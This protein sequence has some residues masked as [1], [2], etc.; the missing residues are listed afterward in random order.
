MKMLF[1]LAAFSLGAN[2]FAD[3]KSFT[4]KGI[5]RAGQDLTIIY[6]EHADE[7]QSVFAD[8][9]IKV[10]NGPSQNAENLSVYLDNEDGFSFG[11]TAKDGKWMFHLIEPPNM[12]GNDQMAARYYYDHDFSI[13]NS[14]ILACTPN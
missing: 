13:R 2:A 12:L 11:V 6:V 14:V 9:T 8:V 4:C 7:R 10:A 1:I 5:N 3:L